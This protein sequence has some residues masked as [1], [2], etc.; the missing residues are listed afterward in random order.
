M[1]DPGTPSERTVISTGPNGVC[2]TTVAV[3]RD[4]VQVIPSGQGQPNVVCVGKGANNFRDSV[5]TGDDAV[6]GDDINTGPDGVCNTTAIAANRMSQDVGSAAT[7]EQY[8]NETVYNQAVFSW[9][10][11]K[12]PPMTV[13]FD[14]NRDGTIDVNTWM[15]PEMT[16]VRDA[17]QNVLNFNNNV[18][19]VDNPSDG[20]FGFADSNQPF[21]FVHVGSSPAPSTTIAHELGHAAFGLTHASGL[22]IPVNLM[23]QGAQTKWRLFKGQWDAIHPQP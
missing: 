11:T 17:A 18:F 9:T 8:L 20:S 5:P 19:L 16:A 1:L 22:G 23:T 6:T 13:N 21:A 15:S 14:L 10:V 7:I 4:D 3:N 2:N 12:F